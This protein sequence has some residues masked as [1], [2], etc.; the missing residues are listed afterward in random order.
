MDN[1]RTY[2]FTIEALNENGVS[3]MSPV[4]KAE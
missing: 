2:Y 1:E 3:P 4:V